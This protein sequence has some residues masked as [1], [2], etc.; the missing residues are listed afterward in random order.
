MA[1]TYRVASRAYAREAWPSLRTQPSGAIGGAVAS[2]WEL[3]RDDPL[4]VP[5]AGNPATL[6]G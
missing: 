5:G 4:L 2:A 6:S 1:H 3:A